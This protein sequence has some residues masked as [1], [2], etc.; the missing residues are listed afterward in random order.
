MYESVSIIV[1]IRI[2]HP[3][4]KIY[5]DNLIFCAKGLSLLDTG[6]VTKEV[7]IS[8]LG[9][10]PAFSSEILK[11]SKDNGLK[12]VRS[13]SK[14]WSRSRAINSGIYAAT[15]SRLFFI[16]ADTILPKTYVQDHLAV[17]LENNYTVNLVYDSEVKEFNNKT[18]DY[19]CLLKQPG[20]IRQGGWSHFSVDR[21]RLIKIGG[22]D[23]D[24]VGWGAEDN[25]VL[26]RLESSGVHRVILNNPPVH[27]WHPQYSE[28][29]RSIGQFSWYKNN[30]IK[31]RLKFFALRDKL[32]G[33]G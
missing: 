32:K 29:M 28:I 6:S 30:K 33:K 7:I 24:Y 20:K 16:D 26:L 4:F 15:G 2:M 18:H 17:A 25:D 12:Y 21:A 1:P 31:N 3:Q 8:D 23:N 9:S 14:A 22:Y 5:I 13:E 11:I 27:L 10:A 19:A